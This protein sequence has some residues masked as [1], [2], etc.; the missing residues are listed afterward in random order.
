MRKRRRLMS[1]SDMRLWRKV[2]L[3]LHYAEPFII[4]D[5]GFIIDAIRQPK[6]LYFLKIDLK[7]GT[8]IYQLSQ[9]VPIPTKIQQYRV[10]IKA[11][12]SFINK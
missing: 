11:K 7:I 10:H 3:T 1:D 9:S 2:A 12:Q 8:Y 4:I 6:S 5:Y